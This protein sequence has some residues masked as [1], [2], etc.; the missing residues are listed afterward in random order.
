MP[1][2]RVPP[3]GTHQVRNTLVIWATFVGSFIGIYL[4]V[5]GR[6]SFG[7]I[8]LAAC[9]IV[10]LAVVFVVLFLR[11]YRQIQRF[12]VANGE[13]NAALGNGD[14]V[15]A[16]TIFSHWA[17]ATKVP[18]V[19]ALARH[20]L[21]WTL[22]REGRL[23]EAISVLT[24]NDTHHAT[25]LALNPLGALSAADLAVVHALMNQLADAQQWLHVADTRVSE[26]PS[27][28]LPGMQAFARAVIDCRSERAH[29]AA[30][31]LDESWAQFEAALTGASLRPI[32]VVRA[33]AHA[34]AGP[35]SAGISEAMLAAAR[36]A[37]PNEY[38]FLGA[39]WPEMQA[40]LVSHDLV[41]RGA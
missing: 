27:T 6:S 36:P 30:C 21:G 29:E 2:H 34:A 9:P 7:V 20:N 10:L 25:L 31:M 33:F 38:T 14:L 22:I 11:N 12:N 28:S 24:D 41:R 15:V 19:S 8:A 4:V 1:R 3:V 13:A 18:M 37:Y 35:R 17:Q 39:A 5:G 23:Q 16:R 32:R 26:P 40:F